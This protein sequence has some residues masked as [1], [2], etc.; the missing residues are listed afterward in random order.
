MKRSLTIVVILAVLIG[1]VVRWF[2]PGSR[3]PAAIALTSA[4]ITLTADTA[5]LPPGP[6]ADLVTSRC[7]ACHSAEMILTQP[8]LTAEQWQ[9]NV[10]KMR[11]VYRADLP[12]SDDPAIL[13]YLTGLSAAKTKEPS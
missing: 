9:A 4:T 11:E 6:H 5:A 13:A 8:P 12:T 3:Q 10:T 2:A 1:G 7:T